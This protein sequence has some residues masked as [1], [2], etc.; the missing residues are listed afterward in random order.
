MGSDFEQAKKLK[1]AAVERMVA[2]VYP[3]VYRTAHGL[4]GREDAAEGV[5]RYIVARAVKLLPAWR[6][7]DEARRWFMHHTV[8]TARRAMRHEAS[9]EAD[10]LVRAAAN[11]PGG[12]DAAYGAFVRAVRSLPQQQ[13][14][15]V[16]LH[17]G[18]HLNERY[19]AVAM[20]CSTQAA[21]THLSAGT[22]TLASMAGE[23]FGALCQRLSAAYSLLAPPENAVAPIVRTMV[24]KALWPRR[25]R[26]M[27][28]WGVV[29]LVL[30][31]A[32]W[33]GWRWRHLAGL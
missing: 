18:E 31:G 9:G 27:V 2:G 32:A 6:D 5:I 19:L 1:R 16:I 3:G 17:L 30:A 23:Q 4:L 10:A 13:K 25:V 8:L 11:V 7:E 15:A 14:E 28:A 22:K 26:K 29:L 24:G 20:D 21:E 12:V 33:A